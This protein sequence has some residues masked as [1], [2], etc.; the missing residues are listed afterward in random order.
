MAPRFDI[1][2]FNYK[3]ID[4]FFNNFYKIINFNKEI[5]RVTIIS[6]SP[7]ESESLAIKSFE[8]QRGF[9]VHY[10]TRKSKG[11]D[12]YARLQYFTGAIGSLFDNL[13][14]KYLF[15]MQEHYLDNSSEHS[16][17]GKEYNYATKSDTVPDGI[18][19]DLNDMAR[20]MENYNLSGMFCDRQNPCWFEIEENRYVAPSG[21]DF[22]IRSEEIKGKSIQV[23]FSELMSVCD[24]TYLWG[25]Y[26]EF[27]W[28][29]IF[30]KEG[31][32]FYD[33]KRKEVFT[34]WEKELFHI[35]RGN[36]PSFPELRLRYK[37]GIIQKA[38]KI[39]SLAR[40][41]IRRLIKPTTYFKGA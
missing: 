30:F 20:L 7:S 12:Q 33:L 19:F 14:F 35:F 10:L 41:K 31:K 6:S 11:V 2:V 18:Q 28:G 1:V 24:D 38:R 40:M 27:M 8:K 22:I 25:L 5:D 23:R 17:W 13:S 29:Y 16:R 37:P 32:R 4:C 36:F 26:M 9:S 3:R 15:L 21:S 34:K 39:V